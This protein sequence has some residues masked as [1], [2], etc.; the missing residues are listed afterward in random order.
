MLL[1]SSSGE[2]SANLASFDDGHLVGQPICLLEVLRRQ[3][4][5]DAQIAV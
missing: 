2:P 5:R 1:F 4:E 3:E